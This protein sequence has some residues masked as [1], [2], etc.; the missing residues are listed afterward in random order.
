MGTRA[1]PALAM[2]LVAC[3]T[4]PSAPSPPPAPSITCA[5]GVY[6]I[7]G[8]DGLLEVRTFGRIA[9][10]DA[11]VAE[12]LGTPTATALAEALQRASDEDVAALDPAS[13]AVLQSDVLG[14]VERV[15]AVGVSSRASEGIVEAG[16]RLALRLAP[17][18][19]DVL[20]IAGELPPGL[21]MLGPGFVERESEMPVLSHELAFGLRRFFRVAVRGTG[22][23]ERAMFSF[24]LGH[25]AHGVPFRTGV[26]GDLEVL[27]FEGDRLVSARL[28]E[29]DRRRLRCEGPA[30]ALTEVESVVQVP[31]LGADRAI[32]AFD[33]PVLLSALPCTRCHDDAMA[34]S[35]PRADLPLGRRQR[36]LIAQ[37]RGLMEAA[38]GGALS[39]PR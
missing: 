14:L 13:R 38:L 11:R 36:S 30:H 21:A 27:R 8:L 35:L 29:L 26:V 39:P 34:M 24:V 32:A 33:P 37:R 18:Y 25:D 28:F 22:D 5:P 20:P 9:L 7:A 16:R 1:V 17:P 2:L 4:S 31:G 3:G 6:A 10:T 19:A 15:S 12:W 23:S